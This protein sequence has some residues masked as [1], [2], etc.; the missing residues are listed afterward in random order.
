MATTL[1]E[2][3]RQARKEAGMTQKDLAGEEYSAAFIS[4]IERGV[5]RPSLQSLQVLAAR[6]KRPIGHFMESEADL[7]ERECDWL[8][9]TGRLLQG[10]GKAA[11]AAKVLQK[12]AQ[13]AAE[14]G[15]R[16]REG[17]ALLGQAR[18]HKA[19][20]NL[21]EAEKTFQLALEAYVQAG[22][23][24]GAAL[25]LIGL[26]GLDE[27]RN[28]IPK[29][30]LD[31]QAALAKLGR[32]GGEDPGLKVRAIGRLALAVYRSGDFVTGNKLQDEALEALK[33]FAGTPELV[34][35]YL[36]T[37]QNHYAAGDVGR[38]LAEAAKG[39][40][41]LDLRA[42]LEVAA[43]LYLNAGLMAEDRGDWEE[44]FE[45]FG[46]AL[47]LY[48][49]A[50]DQRGEVAAMIEAARYHFHAGHLERALGTSEECIEL[51]EKI[52]DP[53]LVGQGRQALGKV[54]IEMKD[55]ERASA[56]LEESVRLFEAAD[57]PGELAD[58]LY[59]LGE[60]HMARGER[61]KALAFFQRAT[62]LFR[63]MGLASGRGNMDDRMVK[64]LSRPKV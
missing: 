44:G 61:D 62:A 48:R 34:L 35:R 55:P 4:Q 1:G 15:N 28:Q 37:A 58:S 25:C 30:V 16:R 52:G 41:L 36:E 23:E 9:A 57:R 33:V 18:S 10:G 46:A 13:E 20:G 42:D 22:E 7:R 50:G 2:K 47:R 29:A 59:E 54:F 5:I 12:A 11:K 27:L 51:A 49:Q 53:A 38:A 6:L 32:P 60:L 43:A 19:Q 64:R 24:E 31:Y 40:A 39:R 8:L 3:I 56:A 45:R 63:K 21:D 14:M 26:G 17:E